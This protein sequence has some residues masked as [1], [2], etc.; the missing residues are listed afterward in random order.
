MILFSLIVDRRPQKHV[1]K[2]INCISHFYCYFATKH[3]ILTEV[4]C[5]I[6]CR[7]TVAVYRMYNSFI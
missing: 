6:E 1:V 5:I 2:G 7:P 4:S 3:V